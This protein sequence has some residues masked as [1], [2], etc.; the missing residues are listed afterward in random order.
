MVLCVQWHPLNVRAGQV[1][2]F[3]KALLGGVMAG[4][5]ERLPI[6]L[7]PKQAIVASVRGFV[8]DHGC[9][10]DLVLS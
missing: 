4:L 10:L 1:A 3:L 8:I 6:G 9:R 5:A 7:I 2:G